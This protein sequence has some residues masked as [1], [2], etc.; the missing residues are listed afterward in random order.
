M[1]PRKISFS[2][3][4]GLNVGGAT[5]WSVNMGMALVQHGWDVNLV[6]HKRMESGWDFPIKENAGI[7]IT[8]CAG[9]FPGYARRGDL[10]A[11]GVAYSHGLPGIIIPNWSV[12]T[13]AACASLSQKKTGVRTIAIVHGMNQGHRDCAVYYE[14][15]IHRF[16]VVSEEI[17]ELLRQQ[18]PHRSEDIIVRSCPVSVPAHLIRR[19]NTGGVV[20]LVYAGRITNYEKKVSLLIPLAEKLSQAGIDYQFDIYGDGGYMPTL[21]W[22]YRTASEA[23]QKRFRIHGQVDPAC[24]SEIWRK[25]DICILVSDAEGSP[26]CVMEAMA[27]GAVPVTTRVSGIPALVQD[28]LT[29]FSVPLGDID[30]MVECVRQLDDNRFYMQ[31]IGQAACEWIQNSFGL[32]TYMDWFEDLLQQVMAENCRVW[33][34]GRNVLNPALRMSVPM[35]TTVRWMKR[36]KDV[37]L[38]RG[39]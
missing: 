26:L 14:S 19:C 1:I 30:A 33:P 38:C 17:G 3:P 4:S 24:M 22:E 29:G 35:G 12:G 27:H 39:L 13:Y 15:I 36:V 10:R 31:S 37:V 28:G 2:L 16:V 7:R 21:Q 25:T 32:D 23:V 18:I 34:R 20:R 11:Y 9:R 6:E 5:V 8:P